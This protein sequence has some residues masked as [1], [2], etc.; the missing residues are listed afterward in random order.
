MIVII[1]QSKYNLNDKG[2]VSIIRNS[3]KAKE[4]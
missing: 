3:R 1:S 4:L 2:T